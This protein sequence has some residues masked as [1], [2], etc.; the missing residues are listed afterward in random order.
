MYDHNTYATGKGKHSYDVEVR[1]TDMGGRKTFNVWASNRDV[2]AR[3]LT[4]DGYEVCSVN[5]TG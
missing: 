2:A 1:T 4:R 5:M 3:R